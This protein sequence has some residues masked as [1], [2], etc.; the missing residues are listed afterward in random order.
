MNHDFREE[1]A[2]TAARLYLEPF[3]L[4]TPEIMTEIRNL[5][6]YSSTPTQFTRELANWLDG[7]MYGLG[8]KNAPA[9]LRDA[10][11]RISRDDFVSLDFPALAARLTSGKDP[12]SL[13]E[14]AEAAEGRER[15][16][17]WLLNDERHLDTAGLI[18]SAD[19]A[20]D[21]DAL[22]EWFNGRPAMLYARD[23]DQSEYGLE[24]SKRAVVAALEAEIG[25]SPDLPDRFEKLVLCGIVQSHDLLHEKLRSWLDELFY[26]ELSLMQPDNDHSGAVA[27]SMSRFTFLAV[28]FEELAVELVKELADV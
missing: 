24:G 19:R 23:M 27:D 26:G 12:D 3:L 1:S 16:A 18:W 10:A 7:H 9:Q 2:G 8:R 4:T 21:N 17:A 6:H 15:I 22:D 28:D 5:Q 11:D 14:T 20:Q 13:E 25:L